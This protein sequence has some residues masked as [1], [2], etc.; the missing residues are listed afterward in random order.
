MEDRDD[1]Q[2]GAMDNEHKLYLEAL[3][4]ELMEDE[5]WEL[6]KDQRGALKRDLA[7]TLTS[8]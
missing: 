2:C 1:M 7:W 3:V 8:L 6:P 5:V 4:E